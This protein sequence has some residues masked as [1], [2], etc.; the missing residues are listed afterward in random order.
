[1]LRIQAQGLAKFSHCQLDVVLFREGNTKIK[2]SRC[3]IRTEPSDLLELGLSFCKFS[4]GRQLDSQKIARFPVFRSKTD[5]FAQTRHRFLAFVQRHI[6]AGNL[7]MDMR[8]FR[9]QVSRRKK[10]LER[11]LRFLLVQGNLAELKA[12]ICEIGP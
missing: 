1:M 7:K 6:R 12:R 2:M 10:F 5:G 9:S 8:I 3:I 11:L 4:M